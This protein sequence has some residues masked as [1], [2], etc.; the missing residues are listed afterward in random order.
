MPLLQ[1][2]TSAEIAP[3]KK[4]QL[5]T[6]LSTALGRVTGKPEAYIMVTA[7]HADTCMAGETC[8][9]AFVDIRGI[10]GLDPETNKKLSEAVCECLAA[11]L[12]IAGDKVYINFTDI[13]ASNWGWNSSTF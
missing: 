5:L 1:L 7:E 12:S 2:K 11:N 13:A 10:G 8:I 6:D 9:A 4:D 3:D